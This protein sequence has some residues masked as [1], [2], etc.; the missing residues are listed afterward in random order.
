VAPLKTKFVKESHIEHY[1][2]HAKANVT[3][4]G[5]PGN[6]TSKDAPVSNIYVDND[7]LKEIGGAPD[8]VT[9]IVLPGKVKVKTLT[10]EPA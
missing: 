3:R 5:G 10:T 2:D 1:S 8:N 7:A 6:K 9:V 4:Y